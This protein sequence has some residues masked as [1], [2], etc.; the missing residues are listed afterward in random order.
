[1]FISRVEIDTLNRRR[2]SEIRNLERMHGWIERCFP[3]ELEKNIRTRKLWRIDTLQGK[4]YVLLVSETKPDLEMLEKYGV[5]GTARTKDYEPFINSL[6]NGQKARFR[7][8]LNPVKSLSDRSG[9]SKR[10]RVIPHITVEHQCEY[11]LDRAQKNGFDL[12]YED[13]TIIERGF[14][15]LEKRGG[16]QIKLV[17]ASYE[18]ILTITDIELFK[19][20]LLK[21]LGKKKAY[22]FGM[23]TVIPVD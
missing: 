20:T 10:G 16:R 9:N 17:K 15:P 6:K 13:F 12:N 3:D 5:S 2:M 19:N 14:V 21:G 18:G 22:G 8:T 7:V 11:L 1:M 23:M 4:K